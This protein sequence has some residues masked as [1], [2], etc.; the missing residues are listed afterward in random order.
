MSLNMLEYNSP[1]QKTFVV[2]EV[3]SIFDKL[4]DLKA[5]GGPMFEQYM[6]NTLLL[7]MDDPES[8]MTL[9]D[10][11][12]VLADED[13]RKYKLSKC[14]NISV[15]DFWEKEA[16]KAGGEASLAN[17]VP[18]ITSKLAPFIANDVMRPII[19][20][21]KSSI[22]F[23]DAMNNQKIVLVKLSIGKLGQTNA[24]LIGMI[25]IGK[26][27]MAAMAR[28]DLPAE[29]RKDFYL[30]IDEFQNFLTD[31]IEIILSQARK[32]KLCLTIGHQ[33]IGQL[34]KNGDTKFKDAI[35]GNVG[36]KVSFRI[37]VD[38]SEALAKEFSPV[39]SEYD[40]LNVEKRNCF[41]K[42]LV[43]GAN[44]PGFNMLTL[45]H[46]EL[47]V[48]PKNE[49]LAKAIKELSRLKYGKERDLI[50]MEVNERIRKT[51]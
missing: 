15:K 8:G 14:T 47:P 32:Y 22:N 21:Q 33:Y 36:S 25:V 37:G 27:L 26:I 4:Y 19:S 1:E 34:V 18:Y 12:K 49:K 48:A 43:D 2:N 10:V 20:Q 11:S 35:F 44:P 45:P 23:A 40:F 5:T 41:V 31:S 39:F 46:D 30:Y 50:E 16:Q 17:M 28:G 24:D 13:F 6:R 9:M 3:L 42:L 29:Q 7:I 51:S 38:D